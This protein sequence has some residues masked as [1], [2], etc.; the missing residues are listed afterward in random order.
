M[1]R[2]FKSA[3]GVLTNSPHAGGENP[4]RAELYSVERLEQFAA[5]LAS[6]HKRVARPKRFRK[7]LPRL[8]D[9]GRVLISV[10]RSLADALRKERAISPA[11][12][13]LVD[14]FHIVEEQLR[15]IREDLPKGYY[16][17]L[18]K[19][20]QGAH[21]GYP[22]IYSVALT[23]VAHTDS[24]LETE[25][26][27]RFIRAYQQE[28]P[29]SIGEL[30]ALAITLR[31][32]LVENLRRLATRIVASRE[33]RE[34]A[35]ALADELLEM[36]GRQPSSLI[37]L[38]VER[39]G[40]R[41]R[42][43]HSFVVQ[44]TR[45]LREQD[46]AV[47]PAYEWLENEVHRRGETVEQVVQ[48]EHQQQAGRQVTVGN[49]ITSMRLLST[50]DWR[51][52]FESVSLV[53][54][55]L[56][57][58]PAG[59]YAQMDFAT[60]DRYRHEVER[61]SRGT[62][63]GEL[64][65]ARRAVELALEARGAELSDTSRAH[66]GFYLIDDGLAELEQAFAYSPSLAGRLKRAVLR[67][68][69]LA[70]LGLLTFLTALIVGALI[71]FAGRAGSAGA[72]LLAVFA[73]LSLIPASDL[74]LNVLNWDFTHLFAPRILP[75]M[76]TAR[77]VPAE[78]RTIVV[79][80]T[81]FTSEAV[82]S[83]L[84]EKLE[85]HYLANRDA[86]I[87]LALLGDFPDAPAE[88]M[89]QDR[90]LLDAALDRIEE[91][92]KRY[93]DDQL[94]PRFFLFHRRRLWNQSEGKWMGWERKRGK[95]HEFNRL[96]RGA[97]DTGFIVA[98]A[99]Q[100]FL[101]QV[102]YVITLD[103]DT[104]LPRDAARKLVGIAT[105]PLNRPRFDAHSRRIT[106]GYG[107]LQPR[108]SVSLES[109]G[110]TRFARIF[111]GG[112]AGLD[113][114]TTAASDVY[115]DLFA[116]GSFTGKGLYDVDAFEAALEGR[117]PEDA[118]LSH[119][120]FEGLYAR[121]ALVTDIELLDDLPAHYDSYAKRTHRWV[122]GDWQIAPWL[123]P[124]VPDAEGRA[125][126]NVLPLISRWKILDNLRRSLV[127]PM[128]L[129]W[130]FAVWTVVPGSPLLWT[131]FIV[132]VL[133]FPVYAHLTTNLLTHPRGIT[134]TSHFWSVWGDARAN[135]A[136]IA[137]ALTCIAHQAYL[138]S[139]A[140]AR[141]LYRKLVSRRRLLEW[142]TAAQAE[143]S[144]T[145]DRTTF[146]H[147][148]WPAALLAV[149]SL[150]LVAWLRPDA[151]AVAAPF[152]IAWFL[153]PLVM[154]WVSRRATKERAP[155]SAKD[156]DALRLIA[157][158][159]WRFF[160]TFVGSDDNWLP[161]DNYQEDPQPVIAHR[162]SPTNTGLLLLSTV[163]AHDFGYVGA[164]E[165]VERLELTFGTLKKL[166]RFRGHFLNWY[167][168]RTLEP[169]TPPYV[170]TVD[171]GN[172]A[173]HLI[174]LKQAMVE[175]PDRVLFD[176]RSLAGLSDTVRL[177]REEAA[178]LGAFRQRT[179][180]VTVKQLREDV[181]KCV[182]ML[183]NGPGQTPGAWASLL[184][185]LARRADII[186]DTIDALSQ[187]HGDHQFTE[188]RFWAGALAHQTRALRRDLDTFFPW[189]TAL[190]S[191]LAA[192]VSRCSP[193]IERQW[194]EVVGVLNRLPP[195][196]QFQETCDE[197]L[198]GLAAL[199]ADLE[200]CE[201]QETPD[202]DAALNGLRMLTASIEEASHSASSVLARMTAL[203]RLSE[204]TFEEMDF[205]FLLD[206]ERKLF[207]I[208]YRV[209]EGKP[210]N[211]F[212]DLLA[213]EARLASFVA[214]SKGDAPQEHWFR[215]GRPLT[216]ADG[217]RALVSWT[218]TMF[219]YLMPLLVMRDFEGTLLNQ[220]YR[221]MVGRQIEYG[222]ERGVPWGVSESAYNARDLQLNYQYGPFGVPGLGLKRG[223]SE[224]LVVAPYATALAALI[225][226]QAA[227]EN[228]RRLEREGVLAR[229]GFYESVDYTPER[230]PPHQ[231]R[232]I[233]H[234]FMTHHQGMSLVAL[235][236]LLYANVMQRRF[237]AEPLVQ[238]TELLLQERI[239]RNVAASHPRAEEVLSSRV[240][241]ALAGRV[242]RSFDTANLPT[243]RTQILSNGT[244]S[245]MV[246]TAGAGYSLCAPVA[247][248]R[249]R[250]DA[251]R[252]HWGSFIY[253]RDARSGMVWST[254][255]Q[256]TGRAPSA[257]EVTF[258]EDKVEI[259]RQDAGIHTRTEI[260][261]SPE[262]DA[263]VRRV[264]L[265]NQSS[266][267]REIEV[268]SYSEVV[269]A[270]PAA[271]AAHPAFS[272]LFIETEFV[273]AENSL[274]ARR[275][276]RSEK[277]EPVWGVHTITTEG[278]TIGAVQYETDR[279]RF[280]GRGR[281]VSAPAAVIEDR[282]LSNT[283]GAVLDPIFSLRQSMRLQPGETARVTFSTMVA[284]SHEEA[285]QLADKYHD[286]GTYGR[287]ASLAWTRSQV[288]MR[289]LNIAEEDAHLFQRLA[290]RILYS[291]PSL[292]PRPH[293]L[294]LN[295]KAQSSL[296]P[297]GISGDLPLVLSRVNRA[298]DLPSVR[299]LL[300]AHEYLRL[301][302]LAFDLVILNDHPPSYLQS[303]QDE[304]LML[305]RASGEAGLM[306]KSG[307]I[308]LR[309]SDQIPEADRILLHAVARV[310]LVAERGSFEE[311]I[312]RKPVEE[313]LPGD[314]VPRQPSRSYPEP[315][316]TPHELTFFN[317]L[318][319]FS[320]DGREYVTVLG[321][322]QWTPAPWSNV[323]ANEQ[324]FGFQVTETGGGYTWSVNSRENRLTPWSNDAVS[325]TPSECVY[326]RDEET[327]EIW[328]PTPLP[329]REVEPY[330]VRHG[331]G[332]TV[333]EHTSHGIAQELLMFVPLDAPVKVCLLRLGNRTARA[334]RLS[335][336]S[337]N[338]LVLGVSRATAA[339]Y[340]ITEIDEAAG[341]L[342][343][344]N[345]Y[346][347]EFANRVAFAAISEREFTWTCDRKE[348]LGRNGSAARP[349]A[350]R[351]QRLSNRTGA[352]LDPC[353]GVQ[354][355][356]EIAPGEVREIV[357]LIGSG[358][359]VEEARAVVSRY[360]QVSEVNEAFE[361]VLQYWDEL[362]GALEVRTPDAALDTIVNRWLLYQTLAC[363]VWARTAF[364]QSGGAY[365]FRDQL[366]DVMALVYA[367][368]EIAREQIVRAASRQ[369]KEGDV[370]HWW[371][372]PTGRGVRTRFSDDLLWLPFVTSFYV[373]VTGDRSVLDESVPFIDAPLLEA[374]ED[375]SYTQPA[376]SS[377]TATVY[378]HCVRALERSLATGAH[379]LPLMG[380][381]DWNDGM[382][383][384]GH[385][386]RGESVWVGW[387]LYSTLASFAP[388]CD[389]RKE[390]ARGLRYRKHMEKLKKA[391]EASGWDGDWYRRAYFDDGTPLGSAQNEECRIDSITQ[392]WGV[393]SGAADP[394]RAARAMAAVEEYLIRRGDGLVILFTPPFDKS[395]LDPGYIKGY[396]PGVRENGGQYTHAAIWTMSAYA[397][398][399]DGDR[400]GELFAL[401]NPINHASTRAGL[402]KYKVEPYVAAGDVYAVWPHTGRGGWTWYTGS[403]GW[404]YRA[405]VEYILGFRLSGDKLQIEPCVPR[406]WRE[407]EIKYRRGRTRYNIKVENPQGVSR[408]VAEIFLD[409]EQSPASEIMLEDDGGAHQV[410]IVLG[411]RKV[412]QV[413]NGKH[414]MLDEARHSS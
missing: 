234:A 350:L 51:D 386:G 399:G 36:A 46:P 30:W 107:V 26:M 323:V 11:A 165:L 285:L 170:S 256:P 130:L 342:L 181:E 56:S 405:A 115:Q 384:V 31:L 352:G 129:L 140:I 60:R 203:A 245:V 232:A 295:T 233:I 99:D 354:T 103:S 330:T 150:A 139:D 297:Y 308:F 67:R 58:D 65:V 3:Q 164:L 195:L 249:W 173:G 186:T 300:H 379:G 257:Y 79:V 278:E 275:R 306:D 33:E 267:V 151:S 43:N 52:F 258:A 82:V 27:R 316:V 156:R 360:R 235:D 10:Y 131:L 242:T 206:E 304:L 290:S 109:A 148:M 270:P 98:T 383:R 231:K 71:Y 171:S 261:V 196:A 96:L 124:S 268:T 136:Q 369:F 53:D 217:S 311:Q 322:G 340:I 328:T 169:L 326:L 255:Y 117:V 200:G 194:Q 110:H 57:D 63:S 163:A 133:A 370:Q 337:Y 62:E 74:A 162:T 324:D 356:V 153:S 157:R 41:E 25:T 226:P 210:D 218:A 89:P 303:L 9:N 359:S 73:L 291:D 84:L 121:C 259:R 80:P 378:E 202:R 407:F 185:S 152:V 269:L 366:Q 358:E 13:W 401:L 296:W 66:V 293:V 179:E 177:M 345:P 284:R 91:L 29:L 238:A 48:L 277:D 276:Q 332:Y 385:E 377:E 288:Q 315:M 92:N 127:A 240:V 2:L 247:V 287:E 12:E 105:H 208:G 341:C 327:G 215:M 271:D 183:A 83:E 17:E 45:R 49:I 97:R 38:L 230:L 333:F 310:V 411:E 406:G 392:S 241:R 334:R 371:H 106:K 125:V 380:S 188:L 138:K 412:R 93:G 266:R 190:V 414:T 329:I 175:M 364:Y 367:T 309:R 64:E 273:A 239:P 298:E 317:G 403:A 344:R 410:R 221:A 81:I 301:K 205:H 213:S 120:L 299:Q 78:A 400:A 365:G 198:M 37:P 286:T 319:G 339:P 224:D 325:D 104:Q 158:R 320:H 135:T 349:S 191:H 112:N 101:S 18:P 199:T 274:V 55:V 264:S 128:V 382:N 76:D 22:R 314:F 122:R 15:E 132:L 362:L 143:S 42:L 86:Q 184:E 23:L 209:A 19:L 347:N 161:P 361:R 216:P 111:S 47:S 389:A 321:E 146:L 32:T 404:M 229:Y 172:L 155:L 292:R 178:R 302:G 338:E 108:I 59:V 159:T 137:L 348:F 279:A 368:P 214:I 244:Y 21:E 8:E 144:A 225:M 357:V 413:E 265:T 254:G 54:P 149:L 85:V 192:I 168:T 280:L 119:D 381:G 114:Y 126:R 77:G 223:L 1:A 282:P 402:H 312:L 313:K 147:F 373:R 72:P 236:N 113:P 118:V 44:L 134:W 5:T 305:I 7:L 243:P 116:E 409:D 154:Y 351:R 197:A 222:G 39:L 391:L 123:L 70:Y 248:T 396:V 393:I 88:E 145:H 193:D 398:L 318:G 387:F 201:P 363:R 394:Q 336:T 289:H 237:H 204:N 95:I 4:I 102:R 176:G 408:G 34:V 35:D 40:K 61:I 220:T 335:V 141:T 75:R 182:E 353:A 375:E 397:L 180:A 174:A 166:E 68:P 372:P 227:L 307:G 262:D 346:N 24:R 253:L 50:L 355:V 187:E 252:D 207:R 211:S 250:E 94:P 16:R 14:N 281:D 189:G 219:E 263:E 294:A 167:D 6:E 90:A 251:T 160:E 142:V 212:Y 390:K 28:T 100:E 374:G 343:A 283:V 331:Q 20:A 272:N 246:T 87:Y 376:V 388:F 228:M 260:I 69:T 395:A